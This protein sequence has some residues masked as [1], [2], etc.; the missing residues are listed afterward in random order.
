LH[1]HA[2]WGLVVMR[3]WIISVGCWFA[4]RFRTRY[5]DV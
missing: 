2:G 1:E 3:I 4:G 5:H